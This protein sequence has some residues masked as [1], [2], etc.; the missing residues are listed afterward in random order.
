MVDF[1]EEMSYGSELELRYWDEVP[2]DIGTERD[3]Y[4]HQR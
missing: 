4:I 3:G 2:G 1:L